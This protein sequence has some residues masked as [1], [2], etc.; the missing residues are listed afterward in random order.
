MAARLNYKARSTLTCYGII[1]P[2][3]VM[4]LTLSVSLLEAFFILPAH[5]VH[6]NFDKRRNA[7]QRWVDE[8]LEAARERCTGWVDVV[9]RWRY[10]FFGCLFGVLLLIMRRAAKIISTGTE[11]LLAGREEL[12]RSNEDLTDAK[13]QLV[14]AGNRTAGPELVCRLIAGFGW[15]GI[16]IVPLAGGIIEFG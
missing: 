3:V 8:K 14:E 7:A 15:V 2:S 6:T 9:I 4:L 11:E 1:L 13:Q 10:L 16:D 12:H 5:L